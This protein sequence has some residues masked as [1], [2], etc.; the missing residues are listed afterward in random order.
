MRHG[1]LI[2]GT[3]LALALALLA[4]LAS[5][6]AQDAAPGVPAISADSYAAH[7][8]TLASDRFAGR[9]PGSEG[10]RLTVDYLVEQFS[11]MGLEPGNDGAWVQDVPAVSTTLLNTDVELDI[12]AGGGPLAL[13]YGAD[14]MA[15]TL[16]QREAVRLDASEVVFLGYGADAPEFGW[17][18]FE[19]VDV[20][21]KTIIVLVNDPG[22]GS[23]DPELFD[24]KAM[25]YYGRWIYKFEEAARKGAAACFVVHETGGAGYAWNVVESSW[26]GPE[27]GLPLGPDSAPALPVAGWITTDAT[28]R[29]FAAAGQD[30]DA[31]KA[32]AHERGF[33]A[34]PL[35]ARASLQLDSRIERLKSHNVLALLPG[36]EAPQESIIYTA[37]WDHLGQDTTLDGD[38]IYNGA[39]DNASGV[40]ALLE[41]ARAFTSAAP[42]PRRS[43]LFVAVTLEESGLLGSEY[44][45]R[46]PALPLET[47]VANINMDALPITGPARN[48]TVVGW[49]NSDLD[50][51]LD[52]AVT[53]QGRYVTPDPTPEQGGFFR[54]DH[55]NF[56][57][58]GVPALYA[59]GGNDLVDGGVAA[60]QALA[61]AYN[62]ER[63]HAP[64][65]NYDPEWDFRG[66]VQD[67][68]ALY[69]VGRRLATSAMWP[70]WSVENAFSA[71]RAQSAEQR[72]QP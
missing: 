5:T 64:G 38:Q 72:R 44:Y 54:S 71:T 12:A 21:G 67:V 63:Y 45:A 59:R 29:L 69:A 25:T 57:K 42:A 49:G 10:E 22:W 40:A 30:F 20:R 15:G 61:R 47:T 23:G 56:A 3:A 8:R 39:I 1:T 41:I 53:A 66:V 37:H 31:L 50:G 28:R 4:P 34:V 70:G 65:D 27:F 35:D 32:R 60:G 13:R 51:M 46:H 36:S 33:R 26:S 17:N 19:G 48:M 62:R 55:I 11:A 16:S 68:H 2:A 6:S 9:S 18:D 14:F 24:G 43:V 58:A 7:L 52:M